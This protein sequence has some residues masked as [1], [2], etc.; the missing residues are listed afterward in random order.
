MTSLC[1]TLVFATVFTLFQVYEYL[2]A[3]FT[4]A[5]GVYG[6]TFYRLTGLHGFHV[7]V[8]TFFLAV[9]LYRLAKH[10]YTVSTHVGYECAA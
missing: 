3:S 6:S 4:I 5:D 7:V 1:L 2:N 8:G 10:H 9:A